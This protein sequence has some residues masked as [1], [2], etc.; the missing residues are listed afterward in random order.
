[1]TLNEYLAAEGLSTEEIAAIVGNEKQ[2]KAMTKALGLADEGRA[3]KAQSAAEK[4]ETATFWEQK[5]KELEG[6]VQ[7]LTKAEQ[8][9]AQ[10]EADAARVKAYNKS[11]ADQ[12]YDIPK[13]MYEGAP[14]N[15]ANP[16]N[17]RSPE[18]GQYLSRE[19]FEKGS[20]KTGADLV[21][22]TKLSNEYRYLYGKEYL[23]IDADFAEAQRQGKPLTEFARQKHG[24]DAKR[25]E[26]EKK[27]A[28]D[29]YSTRYAADL[30]VEK[31]KWAETHGS[32]PDTRAPM[33]SKFDSL[34]KSPEFKSDSWKS[35]EGRKA[36]RD[37]RLKKFENTIQ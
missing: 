6:S 7:K 4:A 9:A 24:F 19:D 2:A 32:N 22:L 30:A 15:P 11:L 34:T 33:P 25:Q 17:P 26:L 16:A 10:A 27:A 3:L 36:N 14:A 12:G 29:A 37:A 21:S 28:E 31:A 23:D 20:R 35:P 5:T 1:L 8:R 18:N 13:E